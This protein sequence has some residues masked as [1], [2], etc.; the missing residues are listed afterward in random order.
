M[1]VLDGFRVNLT[2]ALLPGS[3]ATPSTGGTGTTQ[4]PTAGQILI[5]TNTGTYT[6]P[7]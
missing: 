2:N 7:T 3:L 5:G 1:S 4:V 6:Q